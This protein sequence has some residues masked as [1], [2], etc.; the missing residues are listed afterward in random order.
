MEYCASEN[1]TPDLLQGHVII[2][3][4][5]MSMSEDRNHRDLL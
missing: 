3:V 2:V 5:K 1:V 4:L